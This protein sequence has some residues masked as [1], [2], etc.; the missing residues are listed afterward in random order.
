M[1]NTKLIFRVIFIILI[2]LIIYNYL[3]NISYNPDSFNPDSI[4]V[5]IEFISLDTFNIIFNTDIIKLPIVT[6]AIGKNYNK[7]YICKNDNHTD[8]IHYNKLNEIIK[9]FFNYINNNINNNIYYFLICYNDGFRIKIN[10]YKPID[11]PF[12]TIL[13]NDKLENNFKNKII[14]A[15]SKFIHDNTICFPD[16]VY[17][18]SN[19]YKDNIKLIDDNFINWNDKKNMCIWRGSRLNDVF[20]NFI[21]YENRNLIKDYIKIDMNISFGPR[22]YFIDLYNKS[23]FNNIN[24][25]SEYTS[26]KDQIKYKYI[27]DIDGWSNTWDATFWKL[28]SGSVLLKQKSIWKQWYYD[29]LVEYVHFIPIANDFSDLNEKIQ[30]CIDNDD[31]CKEISEN[32]RKFVSD[33]LNFE[34]VK[35]DMIKI[36]SNIIK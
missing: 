16:Y 32:S 4:P 29:K 27:L 1:V 10:N 9:Y 28:Y 36:F 3:K 22:N 31:K 34:K 11:L 6:A 35:N 13:N 2:I 5:N 7:Y 14:F 19:G 24:Y 12:V 8:N 25:N 21:D 26:I 23:K 30:W 17:L 18:Q 33:N 20:Y 15:F